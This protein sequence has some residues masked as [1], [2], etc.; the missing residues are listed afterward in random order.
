[1]I[2]DLNKRIILNDQCNSK[3]TKLVLLSNSVEASKDENISTTDIIKYA[4]RR[5]LSMEGGY[6]NDPDDSGG[7]TIFGITRKNYPNLKLWK[8]V[9]SK[10]N[11]RLIKLSDHIDEVTM[12]YQK[13]NPLRYMKEFTIDE[14]V[15]VY[16]FAINA[17]IG[18]VRDISEI[19]GA[20]DRS[21]GSKWKIAILSHYNRLIKVPK[22][23]K[24]RKGWQKR[25]IETFRDENMKLEE[26]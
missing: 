8:D 12:V 10:S 4:I 1:M 7:E 22:N 26:V 16:A 21:N 6:V 15:G 11:K 25:L 18:R 2:R 24:F 23:R 5:V 19:Y 17:G 20:Y 3:L 13:Y 9:D 14:F